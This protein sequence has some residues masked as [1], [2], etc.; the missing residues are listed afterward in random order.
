MTG[1]RS[2]GRLSALNGVVHQG[3]FR[4][5]DIRRKL[6]L[7][8]CRLS[9]LQ[10]QLEFGVG[11]VDVQLVEHG[12]KGGQDAVVTRRRQAMQADPEFPA[13]VVREEIRRQREHLAHEFAGLGVAVG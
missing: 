13:F 8:C 4:A 10:H 9:G 12:A 7:L 1:R 11:V 5:P 3:N 2:H 6:S